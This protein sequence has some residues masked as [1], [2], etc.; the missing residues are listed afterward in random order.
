MGNRS[1]DAAIVQA[2]EAENRVVVTKDSDFVNSHLLRNQ[3]SK[4]LLISTGNIKNVELR[5]LEQ[6]LDHIISGL[7]TYNFV[8]LDRENLIF[9]P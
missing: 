9:H 3:P 4:L 8:E 6:N 1:T 2:A 7:S 5:L